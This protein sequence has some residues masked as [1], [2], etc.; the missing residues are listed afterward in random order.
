MLYAIRYRQD[1]CY[2]THDGGNPG[3]CK[4]PTQ[5]RLLNH[6]LA[7]NAVSQDE[8]SSEG[9]D[10]SDASFMT[11]EKRSSRKGLHLSHSSPG[12]FTP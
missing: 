4:S 2:D 1:G 12:P 10:E 6:S 5:A 8:T 3:S 7:Q 11:T 9:E